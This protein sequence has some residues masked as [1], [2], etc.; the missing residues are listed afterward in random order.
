VLFSRFAASYTVA[1]ICV[2]IAIFTVFSNAVQAHLWTI[3]AQINTHFA[4]FLCRKAIR[5]FTSKQNE[6]KKYL[7]NKRLLIP[8]PTVSRIASVTMSANIV[9]IQVLRRVRGPTPM[10]R[11]L[12]ASSLEF[13]PP[14]ITGNCANRRRALFINPRTN[15]IMRSRKKMKVRRRDLSPPGRAKPIFGRG[16]PNTLVAICHYR[17]RVAQ[18]DLSAT[19]GMG[20][21]SSPL[22]HQESS[23]AAQH[24]C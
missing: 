9:F 18:R 7:L 13:N 23:G 5:C 20:P 10:A 24:G 14:T 2:L 15:G 22:A 3:V 21:S 16:K 17:N 1:S 19:V 4:H 6:Q 12:L 8:S 11:N